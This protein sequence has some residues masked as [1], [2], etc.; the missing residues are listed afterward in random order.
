[1]Y[2]IHRYNFEHQLEFE[3]QAGA[4]WM[5]TDPA[6]QVGGKNL[7]VSIH[8]PAINGNLMSFGSLAIKTG[9]FTESIGYAIADNG[10]LR[11]GRASQHR[12]GSLTTSEKA[13]VDS[14]V[15]ELNGLLGKNSNRH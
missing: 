2:T 12:Y 6:R 1:M 14:L 5:W 9:K 3:Q 13:T 11:L 4:H 15:R 8:N 7:Y 10:K